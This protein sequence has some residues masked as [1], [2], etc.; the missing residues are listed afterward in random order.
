MYFTELIVQNVRQFSEMRRYALAGG[1][2]ALYAP[3][4]GRAETLIKTL[5]A[6]LY[7]SGID[8]TRPDLAEPGAKSSRAAVGMVGRDGK[9]YRVMR[10]FVSG[11]VS[12]AVDTGGGQYQ[13]LAGA[14]ND[15][16]QLLTAQIGFVTSEIFD[17]LLLTQLAD[18]PSRAAPSPLEAMQQAMAP[19]ALPAGYPVVAMPGTMPGGLPATVPVAMAA[20][21]GG[22][23]PVAA[24]YPPGTT[25]PGSAPLGMPPGMGPPMVI[26]P[27][28]SLMPMPGFVYQ[29]P[30]QRSPFADLT[31]EQKQ[32]KLEQL[33]QSL[34]AN[35]ELKE[36]E[37]ELDGL[38]RRKFELD[39]K[40]RPLRDAERKL[41]DTDQRLEKF[42]YL[43]DVPDDF[44]DQ[45]AWFR[46]EIERRDADIA[47]LERESAASRVGGRQ[48]R[49][50]PL[51][52]D[53]MF[54]GGLAGGVL[55]FVIGAIAARTSDPG[56]WLISLL[57]IPAFGL[58][59]WV[60]LRR[61][62]V[63]E[64]SEDSAYAVRKLEERKQRVVNRFELDT[65][66]VR[67]VLQRHEV[68]LK[69]LDPFEVELEQR[70]QAQ[71]EIA[72]QRAAAEEQRSG[73]GGMLEQVAAEIKQ[74][75]EQCALLED[76]ISQ[77]APAKADMVELAAQIQQLE[78]DLQP[79]ASTAAETVGPDYGGYE[80]GYGPGSGGLSGGSGGGPPTQARGE[81]CGRLLLASDS[82][83]FGG[84][85][86]RIGDY[87]SG[88]A[89]SGGVVLDPT[90]R[91]MEKAAEL[92]GCSVEQ[93]AAQIAPRLG[94]YL[95][96]FTDGRYAQ[97]GFGGRGELSL[98]G[99]GGRKVPFLMLAPPERDVAYVSL[100]FTVLEAQA[101]NAPLPIVLN[102]PFASL[103]E[104]KH[105]L[106]AKM[107]KYVGSLTQ[108]V[109]FTSTASFAA[110]ADQR[111]DL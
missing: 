40:I 4:D 87:G 73:T 51:Y 68:D 61:I 47:T 90:R 46:K 32:A 85:G 78:N 52:T 27:D 96:A 2:N 5:R 82:S 15:V 48:A 108:V 7:P 14:V 102:D 74:L 70:A 63:W 66:S 8:G 62:A 72:E 13:A 30:Q 35:E 54:L 110:Q 41:D 80:P 36:L 58:A 24:S 88:G 55:A 107:L 1:H 76:K 31:T 101:R 37:F 65:A 42:A 98:V 38:Q 29:Q 23:V 39:D 11:A 92:F 28:G 79:S 83:M 95:A 56:L 81:G 86:G 22:F 57:D 18:M 17:L 16:A 75:D 100:K 44:L 50:P 12:L 71:R 94:Q 26:G 60:L 3:P 77:L 25:G 53:R 69:K 99:E 111:I 34:A 20:V 105:P 64:Q 104:L 45:L 10:D 33:R 59:G 21:P 84:G 67:Q 43:R 97:V 49:L 106:A 9:S 93:A 6:L 109:H 19:T 103:A 91:I 89:G